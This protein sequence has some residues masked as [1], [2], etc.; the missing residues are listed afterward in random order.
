MN[1]E[2]QD[3]WFSL[4]ACRKNP[5]KLYVF[6]DNYLRRGDA[7]Q[8]VIRRAR[9]AIGVATKNLPSDSGNAY[10]SDLP[11]DAIIIMQDLLEIVSEYTLRNYETIVF[12]AAGLGSGLSKMPTKSPKLFKWM[13]ETISII[14]NIEYPPVNK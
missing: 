3:E 2:I 5:T 14:F 4:E 8:A 7:G 9:N 10:F 12:P 1:V 11:E 6:G 13:N